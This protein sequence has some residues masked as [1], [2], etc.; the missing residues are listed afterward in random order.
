M[1]KLLSIM[2]VVVITATSFN[3]EAQT[4]SKPVRF[5]IGVDAGVPIGTAGD[6]YSLIIGGSLLG[7]YKVASDL[8]LTLSAGYKS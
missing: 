8:G 6:V 4:T 7:E 2:A 3:A 1:K 5:G